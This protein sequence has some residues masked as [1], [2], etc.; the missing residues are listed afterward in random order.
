MINDDRARVLQAS[1]FKGNT[2]DALLAFYLDNGASSKNINKAALEFFKAQG[3]LSDNSVDAKKEWLSLIS[4][5]GSVN[6]MEAAAWSKGPS[7][8]EFYLFNGT[9][10]YIDIPTAAVSTS[11]VVSIEFTA[12]SFGSNAIILTSSTGSE[13]VWISSGSSWRLDGNTSATLDGI[14]LDHLDTYVA[15]GLAHKLEITYTSPSDI[16]RIGSSI[17]GSSPAPLS[18]WNLDINGERFY[19]IDDGWANNPTI[20]DNLGDGSTDGVA[21]NFVE[22]NWS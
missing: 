11:G 19:A 15:D 10:N 9:N 12:D 4:P 20:V 2:S 13:R 18:I 3:A 22:G 14:P 6:D 21:K 8:R 7:E 16:S 1:G 5:H 17:T